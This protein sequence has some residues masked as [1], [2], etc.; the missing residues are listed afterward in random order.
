MFVIRVNSGSCF[1][2]GHST[3]SHGS[4]ETVLQHYDIISCTSNQFLVFIHMKERQKVSTSILPLQ[5][6]LCTPRDLANMFHMIY[7]IHAYACMHIHIHLILYIETYKYIQRKYITDI[8]FIFTKNL[9]SMKLGE[10][11]RGRT[12]CMTNILQSSFLRNPDPLL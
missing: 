11:N 6:D 12:R 8:S 4:Q 5:R 7:Y 10:R 1:W 9:Q 2:L 3:R